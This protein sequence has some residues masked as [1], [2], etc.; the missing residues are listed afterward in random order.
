MRLS[1]AKGVGVTAGGDQLEGG[2]PP[3]ERIQP[4]LL[5]PEIWSLSEC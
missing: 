1:G 4:Y 2:L 5:E 3:P